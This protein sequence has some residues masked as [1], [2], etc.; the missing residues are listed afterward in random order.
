MHRRFTY[1][2]EGSDVSGEHFILDG[3]PIVIFPCL[4]VNERMDHAPT[5]VIV[6]LLSN[7]MG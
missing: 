4:P 7:H 5:A 1:I 3:Y 2:R 6:A